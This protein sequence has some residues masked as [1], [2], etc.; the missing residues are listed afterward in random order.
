MDPYDLQNVA[1][2]IIYILDHPKEAEEMGKKAKEF[3]RE[4][5]LITRLVS[6]YLDLFN[7]ILFGKVY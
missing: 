1:D 6:D 3:V 5:F 4:N 7:H 2:K